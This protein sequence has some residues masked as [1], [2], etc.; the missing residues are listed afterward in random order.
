MRPSSTWPA[1]LLL[2]LL[3]A[4]YTQPALTPQSPLRCDLAASK[5]ECPAGYSCVTGGVCAPSICR[6]DVE[7]PGGFVC[8]GRVCVMG[9]DGGTRDGAT[10]DLLVPPGGFDGNGAEANGVGPADTATPVDSASLPD[11]GRD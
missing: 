7:C 10:A 5:G 8:A 4:C 6:A 3:S 11:G 9:N 2:L 1:S